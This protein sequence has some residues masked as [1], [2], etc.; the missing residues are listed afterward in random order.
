MYLGSLTIIIAG[1][2]AL[3]ELDMKKIIALS[4]LSQLGVMFFRLG[5]GQ[6]LFSLLHLLSHAYFKAMLFIAAGAIIHSVKDYQDTRKIGREGGSLPFLRAVLLI[7]R[8]RLCGLPFLSG[9]YSKDLILEVF[10]LG[11]I[12]LVGGCLAILGTGLT[13]IYSC[14]LVSVLMVSFSR[15]EALS[16][17]G[18]VDKFIGLGMGTLIIPSVL[19]GYC[20]RG[21]MPFLP[22][23]V[24]RLWEKLFI[25]I[26]VLVRGVA[27]LA[28][29]RFTYNPNSRG[30]RGLH[31]I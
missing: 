21:L 7:G 15:R 14:R 28:W 16:L 6:P 12:S 25:L 29:P 9:F 26:L 17:E 22:C 11:Q 24:F 4:T 10:I 3:F 18:D 2:A 5:I 30:S 20:L 27:A 23:I 8:L 13:V 19:G 31:Q 1:L